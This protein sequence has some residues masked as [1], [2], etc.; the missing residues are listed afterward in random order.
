MNK[1]F[2]KKI[3]IVGMTTLVITNMSYIPASAKWVNDSKNNWNWLEDKSKAI[4]W[5][6]IDKKWYYF[7]KDGIMG[8]GWLNY[9]GSWYNL[10]SGGSMN[11]GWKKI[12]G[13]WYHFKDDGSMSIGWINDNGTWYFTN[14]NGEMETGT[15][16]IDGKVYNFSDS[17]AL[18]ND[19]EVIQEIQ[20]GSED[21]NNVKEKSDPQIAYVATNSGSLNIRFDATISSSIIG[22]LAKGTEVKIID[23]ERNGFY[24]IIANGK[25]G[26]VNSKWIS[27]QEPENVEPNE[28]PGSDS[29][30]DEPPVNSDDMDLNDD[31]LGK[32]VLRDTEPSLDNKYYYSNGNIFYR[33]KLSPPFYSGEKQIKGNCTWYAWGRA[34][35]LTG[36][37]PNDAGFIGNGY[38]WW[39][40]NKKSGKY[41]YGS[42][43]KVGA[44]AVWKSALPNS[45]GSGHVAVVERIENNKIYISESTWHGS[46]FKYR[47]IYETSYL[48]G[49]IYLDKPNY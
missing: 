43:P 39:E 7:N 35:E 31:S 3:I 42:Q 21:V 45:G 14:F 41:E 13:K 5:K 38:E 28:D 49:Y 33:V 15:L 37:Q 48:Y 1:E 16:G 24:P 25:K 23:D 6:E 29:D 30:K 11:I 34:W 32:G 20:H 12:D 8:T 27:F 36:I 44:I 19:K 2:L 17:G 9:N 10:S 26:W 47:E 18:I 4:G 46:A 22:T 40:A